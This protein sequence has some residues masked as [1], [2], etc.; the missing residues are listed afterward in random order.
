MPDDDDDYGEGDVPSYHYPDVDELLKPVAKAPPPTPAGS[1][2]ITDEHQ[3]FFSWVEDPAPT[4]RA[5]VL[6]AVAGSGKTATL[7][8][9]TRRIPASARGIY[10]AFNASVVKEIKNQLPTNFAA[11]TLHSLGFRAVQARFKHQ[12][13]GGVDRRKSY[14]LFN[15]FTKGE[16]PDFA[17]SVVTLVGKAKAYGL[18]PENVPGTS[19]LMPDEPSSWRW[20]IDRFKINLPVPNMATPTLRTYEQIES[21]CIEIARAVLRLG[22]VFDADHR[23]IDFD[24]QLYL[25]VAY[26]LPLTRYDW[27]L[28]D[29]AQDISPVQRKMLHASVKMQTGRLIA[30]GDKYQAIYGFRGADAYSIDNI[31]KEFN[32][33]TFSL[34][35]TY[36]CPRAVVDLARDYVPHLRARPG[37]APG[38]IDTDVQLDR[39]FNWRSSDLV[40]CRNNAPLVSLAHRLLKEGV[41]CK[42]LGKDIG[43]GVKKIVRKLRAGDLK[44]LLY[45]A[46]QYLL[47]Q[48]KKL[49]AAGKDA[50][51][52][53]LQDDVEVLK[54]FAF[55]C[56]TLPALEAMI[57]S[58]F[59]EEGADGVEGKVLLSTIHKIKG[60]EAPRVVV[61]DPWRMPSK[62]AKADWE[63][64]QE[65]NIIY[66]AYTRAKRELLFASLDGGPAVPPKPF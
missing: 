16:L 45:K 43:A 21:A 1:F 39:M 23:T 51:I 6:Q 58:L 27:V 13:D 56:Q 33:T 55:E 53:Q 52:E 7:K 12:L 32:A 14:A 17:D 10:L 31:I 36:R 28:V 41:P 15:E 34:S 61:L 18:V 65:R 57:E 29:E 25:A 2:T 4:H 37:A 64:Q 8:Q 50:Q 63:I 54:V 22:L 35:V 19:G 9:A 60:G 46:D 62:A 49:K 44:S 66:V 42:V 3:A 11:L 24:D 30:V 47:D 59:V 5:A 26:R 48:T 40:L 20:L 38:S